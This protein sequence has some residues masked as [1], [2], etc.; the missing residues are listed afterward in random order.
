[1]PIPAHLRAFA[2]L[3]AEG[4]RARSDRPGG[5]RNL[6]PAGAERVLP[7]ES[8]SRDDEDE[9]APTETIGWALFTTTT[10]ERTLDRT[11]NTTI[12]TRGTHWTMCSSSTGAL[13]G[14][15]T[16]L[17]VGRSDLHLPLDPPAEGLQM[18]HLVRTHSRAARRSGLA[19]RIRAPRRGRG[20]HRRRGWARRGTA[21]GVSSIAHRR[22]G[23]RSRR[24]GGGPGA[25][26]RL[27]GPGHARCR[28]VLVAGIGSL[29]SRVRTPR[30]GAPRPGRQLP[31]AR[32]LRA[33]VLLPR[34][35]APR[36]ADG[37]DH[38][39]DRCRPGEQPSG[40]GPGGAVP[41]ERR[42]AAVRA[43]RPGRRR[44]PG[45]PTSTRQLA[46]VVA[47]AVPAPA[48]PEGP[49]GPS[50]VPGTPHC[51]ERRAGPN[52]RPRSPSP[53]RTWRSVVCAQ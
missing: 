11:E 4:A 35:R 28:P 45:R 15:S 21:R 10:T 8:G 22:V 29:P 2:Q 3:D 32:P 24:P 14:H 44:E 33:G 13:E 39:S 40:G 41:R 42:G 1:M 19:V 50:G 31:S 12:R 25:L 9:V 34:G 46:E 36:H 47:S 5:R 27:R 17:H 38:G 52:S 48:P 53:C 49:P 20:R 7:E 37:P 51:G 43:H 18:A 26:V 23:P 6:V 16:H 30:W